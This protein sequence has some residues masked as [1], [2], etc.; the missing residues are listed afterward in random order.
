M[1]LCAFRKQLDHHHSCDKPTNVR[2][3][4][5]AAQIAP[6]LRGRQ[7]SF[8]VEAEAPDP[9]ASTI[10]QL[11]QMLQTM[12]AD[13]FHLAFH[14]ETKEFSG[15][16][17]TPAKDGFKLKEAA[18]PLA[19]SELTAARKPGA[20]FANFPAILPPENHRPR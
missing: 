18:G 7:R 17:L 1:S 11:R 10:E 3:N 19:G 4:R 14:K 16:Y 12:L 6:R 20:F 15:Y 9:P 8:D 5:Y 2:P 13:Q